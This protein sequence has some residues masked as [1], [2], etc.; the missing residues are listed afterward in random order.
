MLHSDKALSSASVYGNGGVNQP[1]R[2]R[3]ASQANLMAHFKNT[4]HA[5]TERTANKTAKA[6]GRLYR[7]MLGRRAKGF[8]WVKRLDYLAEKQYVTGGDDVEEVLQHKLLRLLARPNDYMSG[9][10]H[11]VYHQSYLDVCGIVY[12]RLLFNE[13]DEPET[14]YLLPPNLVQPE[15]T[16]D[17]IVDYYVFAGNKEDPIPPHEMLIA[18]ATNLFNPYGREP[19]MSPLRSVMTMLGIQ[20]KAQASLNSVLRNEGMPSGILAPR[21]ELSTISDD[22]RERLKRRYLEF[23]RM[24]AGNVMILDND[25]EYTP[26]S[27]KPTDLGVLDIMRYQEEAICQAWHMPLMIHRGSEGQS[28]AAYETS[29]QEWCD[30]AISTRLREIEDFVN[31]RLLPFFE[32]EESPYFYCF[33]D[34]S[35]KQ[36]ELTQQIV[37]DYVKNDLYQINEGRALLGLSPTP[38]GDMLHSE[39]LAYLKLGDQTHREGSTAVDRTEAGEASEPDSEQDHEQEPDYDR[40]AKLLLEVA[41]GGLLVEAAAAAMVSLCGIPE[42]EVAAML[43]PY[44]GKPQ[45]QPNQ[46]PEPPAP[47]PKTPAKSLIL[48]EDYTQK[49][50]EPDNDFPEA[51]P[52]SREALVELEQALRKNFARWRGKT[53]GSFKSFG[54]DKGLPDKFIPVEDWSEELAADVAPVIEVLFAEAGRQLLQ[55]VGASSE[56]FDVFNPH[57]AEWARNAALKLSQSTLEKTSKDINQ[58]LDETRA[59]LT[60]SMLEGD[61]ISDLTAKVADVFDALESWQCKRIAM[62]EASIAHNEGHRQGAIDSGVVKGFKWLTSSK[63]CPQCAELSGKFIELDSASIP[64]LHP[65]CF[66]VLEDVLSDSENDQ[67]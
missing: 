64:P 34:P 6:T 7:R 59:A 43:R 66:C 27:W 49:A 5:V 65:H 62:T 16:R 29:V 61:R 13:E 30:G 48:P 31:L 1:I 46:T 26:L 40:A 9:R 10:E 56:V 22:E 37:C 39:L 4:V 20:D 33:D 42:A 51:L 25:M 44:K 54:A 47:E 50:A 38:N 63:P 24:G 18:T 21:S 14:I 11:W 45:P 2:D 17:G 28:R 35:P 19:G 60:Q 23:V 55:R 41:A 67:V 58:A 12:W 52:Y 15:L 8:D 32:G 36:D 3:K 57:V 53:L